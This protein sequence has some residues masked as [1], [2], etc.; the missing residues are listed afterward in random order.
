MSD[1]PRKDEQTPEVKKELSGEPLPEEEL[2]KVAGGDS[3]GRAQHADL[4]IQK[5][6]DAASPK[7]LE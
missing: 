7:L 6:I 5:Y 3:S 4:P 2:E 1:Q